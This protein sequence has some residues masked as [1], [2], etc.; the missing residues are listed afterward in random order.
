MPSNFFNIF[1][2]AARAIY[3][4]LL[5]RRILSGVACCIIIFIVLDIIFPFSPR[6]PYS[7]IVTADDG[8]VMHAL[9]ASDDKWRMKIES[10]DISPAMRRV[11]T[12]KE[13][14]W[15]YWHLGV[16]PLAIIRAAAKNIIRGKTTSGASTI[17]MQTARLLEP[18]ERNIW[19]KTIEIFRAV[20]LEIHYSKE[21]ILEMYLAL[22][23][24]GG[25]IEGIKSA[26]LLYFGVM[27]SK[28]SPAQ[29]TT[30]AVIPNRPT[31]LALGKNNNLIVEARNRWLRVFA[32]SDVFSAAEVRNAIS[33]P[34]DAMRRDPPEI[35]RHLALRLARQ[36]PDKPIIHSA[37][38]P[39]I[40]QKVQNLCFNYSRVKALS[41]VFNVSVIVINNS[42][43][44]A[45][46]YIGNPNFDDDSHQGQVDGVK[47]IRSPGSTLK[48]LLYA[49]AF[50]RG[51][52]T[53][54]SVITDVPVNFDGFA[55]ENYNRKYNGLVTAEK[56]L[57]FSLNV[58]AVKIMNEL[59]IE[60][61]ID[62]LSQAGFRRIAADR[63][64]LG[65]SVALGGCGVRLEEIAALFSAFANGGVY[66]ST[67]FIKEEPLPDSI[68][69]ISPQTAYM[70]SEIL[71]QPTRPDLPYN[72]ESSF[73]LPKIAWKTG[74]S[75]GRRDA[76][77]IGFNK[78]YTIG[79]WLGNFTG[80]GTPEL[81]G[82]DAA[83]PLL[84]AI[85]NSLE[86]AGS[87][88]W[89]APPKGLDF[90]Y[91]CAESGLLPADFCH[92]L[93]MDYYI[94]GISSNK[95]CEH[96]KTVF[97][98]PDSSVGY[99]GECLPENG[100]IKADYPS[101]PPE[102]TAFYESEHIAY[103]KIPEH[104]PNCSRIFT[105]KPPAITS[106]VNGKIYIV[107]SG[108]DRK[109]ML[110][111]SANNDVKRVYWYIND[112]FLISENSAKSVFFIPPSGDVKISCSDDK[113]RNSNIYIRVDNH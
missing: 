81:T 3:G 52:A 4:K 49:M 22:V 62:K 41:G 55:P 111:C 68:R 39:S 98:S 15:F 110:S 56:S 26:A 74:T 18:K 7:Q 45:E 32:E 106:P 12:A 35:A 10:D 101:I 24:Y 8:T 79:V 14:K 61:V 17:T 30:L 97:I 90:R 71:T 112:R 63:K 51:I 42:T 89:F 13:D 96:R 5:F 29:V 2:R 75:Y 67:R 27:P 103:Q 20:Q 16:N 107:E 9:L 65:L 88:E 109:I 69:I 36:Y 37:I 64:H 84:F 73:R 21:E 40:Q 105:D 99:C 72:A 28:L 25:N 34:L 46:A 38:V 60:T 82:A 54:K 83:T 102:L 87:N 85:F 86:Y 100:Y 11:I 76:W 78:R 31:S 95:R 91:V 43:S 93:T 23:P 33:E 66:R 6:I 44:K 58:P 59:G 47:A 53:P 80:T 94:P 108:E 70:L 19:N 77:S 113:G 57:A 92:N 104:N 1:N 50:D 48:P